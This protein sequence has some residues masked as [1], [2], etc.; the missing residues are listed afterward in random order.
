V[1]ANELYQNWLAAW[2]EWDEAQRRRVIA[3]GI[4]VAVLTVGLLV[5]ALRPSYQAL[6]TDLEMRDAAAIVDELKRMKVPYRLADSGTKILVEEKRVHETR[7]SLMGRGVPLS[8]GVGF[9][10]FD[11]KDIG[12]TEYTQKINY[13]RALQG[14]L[15]RTVMAISQVKLAR[16]HLVVAE[17]SIF[18]RQY[19]KPKASVSLVLKP[20]AAL[21]GDQIIGIQRLVAA[22]VPG[23]EPGAVTVSDQGGVT[24][25]AALE[26][27][28]GYAQI[29]GKL[30]LK[31]NAEDYF[32]RKITAV[33]DR[34][35]RP[36][37]AIV[38]V[39]VDLNFDEVKR[40]AQT[41]IPVNSDAGDE[42]GAVVRKRQSVVR[43][44]KGPVKTVDGDASYSGGSP[45]MTSSTDVEYEL[46]KSI[47]QVVSSPGG[48]RRISVGLIVPKMTPEQLQRVQS[49]V[50]M[51][52]G[53]NAARG[54]AISI[55]PLDQILAEEQGAAPSEQTVAAPA[56]KS[57]GMWQRLVNP[58]PVI[59]TAILVLLGIVLGGLATLRFRRPSAAE[60]DGS[61]L[62]PAQRQARLTE[63]RGWLDAERSKGTA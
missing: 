19:I 21:S 36:G 31:R 60:P 56:I 25:S 1:N 63:I 2:K 52:V 15:A 29:S 62:T 39:D 38:S 30:K 11:N 57:S 34:T 5:W 23:L 8:G 46:G 26:G 35:F 18:K 4:A 16:V 27:D 55:Q 49:V 44:A 17:S 53:Y 20:G 45:D 58:P 54:D 13:Q 14:E 32:V 9:E 7:L 33:L 43:G 59:L 48:I 28:E 6:F 50:S 42:S 10:I 61:A 3:G 24:L 12:M 22:S 37:Q 41:V 51:I 47:E 40:T